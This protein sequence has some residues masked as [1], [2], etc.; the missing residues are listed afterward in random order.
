MGR[1]R[2]AELPRCWE[3]SLLGREGTVGSRKAWGGKGEGREGEGLEA[4]DEGREG[5]PGGS[6]ENA[7]VLEPGTPVDTQY[8]LSE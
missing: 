7:K 3:R 8:V 1:R 6:E 5:F 2:G 4:G